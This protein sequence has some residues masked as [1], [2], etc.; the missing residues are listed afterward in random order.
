MGLQD[1]LL[2]KALNDLTNSVECVRTEQGAMKDQI[3]AAVLENTGKVSALDSRMTSVEATMRHFKSD[4]RKEAR[5]WG[6]VGGACSGALAIIIAL[7][8]FLLNS[9]KSVHGA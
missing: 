9:F 6:A 4:V 2:L 7:L 3:H 5:R 8:K 1:D